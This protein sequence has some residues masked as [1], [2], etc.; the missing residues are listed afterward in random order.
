MCGLHEIERK[1]L[2]KQAFE[3]EKVELMVQE[4]QGMFNNIREL[5]QKVEEFEKKYS[6]LMT[7]PEYRQKLKALKE[8]LGLTGVLPS[9][10][11]IGPTV[12][13]KLVGKGKFYNLLAVEILEVVGNRAR[14][15]GGILTLA[16]VALMISNEQSGKITELGD[17]VKAIDVLKDSGL[18][19]GVKTLPSGVRVVEFLPVE[20]A[21]DSNAVLDLAAEKGWVTAEELMF[22]T[23]WPKARAERALKS[24]EE[25]GVT[26]VDQSYAAGTRW[27]FPGLKHSDSEKK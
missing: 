23:R 5:R 13:E 22:K 17:I 14:E 3:K 18:V 4:L 27:Y 8:E 20:L 10:P 1:I 21:D 12:F 9:R 6:E 25:L 11:E 26:R 19:T 16:E 15:S 2:L 24:L 7:S